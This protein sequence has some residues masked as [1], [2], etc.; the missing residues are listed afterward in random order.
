MFSRSSLVSVHLAYTIKNVVSKCSGVPSSVLANTLQ[1]RVLSPVTKTNKGKCSRKSLEF[2]QDRLQAYEKENSDIIDQ[3]LNI[4]N[5]P[6]GGLQ[7]KV[8][9]KTESGIFS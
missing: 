1:V 2:V 3:Y 5:L 6:E 8:V 9:F 4:D 7:V